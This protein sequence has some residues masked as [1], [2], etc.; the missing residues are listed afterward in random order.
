MSTS[1]K[2]IGFRHD[3]RNREFAQL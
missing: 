1:N 3:L 2:Q